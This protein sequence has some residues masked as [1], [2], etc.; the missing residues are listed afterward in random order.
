MATLDT[1]L[2]VFCNEETSIDSLFNS[3]ERVKALCGDKYISSTDREYGVLLEPCMEG[4]KACMRRPQGVEGG[5]FYMYTSVIT[6]LRV[7][8]PSPHSR[9]TF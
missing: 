4:E 6:D 8:I 5:Y 1:S 7:E 9:L 3:E 2:V